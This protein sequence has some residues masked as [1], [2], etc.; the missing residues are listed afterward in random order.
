M[1]RSTSRLL[2]KLF[3]VSLLVTI[4]CLVSQPGVVLAISQGDLQSLYT[5]SVYYDPNSSSCETSNSTSGS[6]VS[7][8][9]D[10]AKIAQIIIGIA[11]TDKLGKQG[12][13]VGL[14]VGLDESGLKI[15]ANSNVPVSLG[16]PSKQAIGSDHDS[17]GVF[18]QRISTDWSTISSDPGDAKAV[19]QLMDPAYNAQA[20]FGSPPGSSAPPALSKGLQNHTGWR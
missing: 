15:Y 8:S 16:I 13:L 2:Y 19:A 7:T 6:D 9:A 18:Q 14:M 17:L 12:A 5:D 1:M 10:Q 11:K 4:L 3:G 20:F